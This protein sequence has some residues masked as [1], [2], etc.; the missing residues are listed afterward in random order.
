[1]IAI[2]TDIWSRIPVARHQQ[3]IWVGLQIQSDLS[4]RV[5]QIS[6]AAFADCHLQLQKFVNCI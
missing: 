5:P 3:Q 6:F 4:W 1:M 2:H